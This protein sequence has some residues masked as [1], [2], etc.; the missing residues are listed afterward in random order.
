MENV[1]DIKKNKNLNF[2]LPLNTLISKKE[3]IGNEKVLIVMH[4]FYDALLPEYLK[5]VNSV[6]K[7]ITI[8]FTSSNPS[9]E[10]CLM[11]YMTES[12]R[13]YKFIKK[14]NQGRD[15]SGLLVACREE[16]QK[17]RYVCFL[18][19]KKEKREKTKEDVK[20]FVKCLWENMIGSQEYIFNIISIFEERPKLGV[21]FP[22][23]S[24][25]DNFS[26]FYE[27]TW[28][29][30][31]ELMQSLAERMQLNCDLDRKKKPL[32]LGTVFW[33]RVD[34]LKKLLS[35]EWKYNDFDEEPL[36]ADG[37]LSHAI[38]RCFAYVA[39]DA[40]YESGIVMTDKFAGERMDYLQEIMTE[41]FDLMQKM[42]GIKKISVLKNTKQLYDELEKFVLKYP[43]IYIYGAGKYGKRYAD[44]L[45]TMPCKIEGF[46]VSEKKQIEEAPQEIPIIEIS[47]FVISEE[48]GIVVAVSN[49]FRDEILKKL[50]EK[51]LLSEHIF[52]LDIE[53]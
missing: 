22:P 11:E 18:H 49:K 23:E 34:A 14:E 26:Y 16:I 41:A 30:D 21:L 31:F 27:N 2:I 20:T 37:T 12:G 15:I 42:L 33:A 5:Y 46:I 44:L 24:I 17:Y 4:L 10:K 8:L 43:S 50:K 36:A 3:N 7:N 19:D 13:N 52:C 48:K 47:Q 45:R 28:Y 32:S 35:I 38:E 53:I 39:Q 29:I 25:S 1:F 6:P 9:I 51:A 40:G